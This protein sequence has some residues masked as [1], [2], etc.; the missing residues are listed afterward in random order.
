MKY[1]FLI[2]MSLFSLAGT[3]ST[4]ANK[5]NGQYSTVV[6][7]KSDKSRE[8]TKIKVKVGSKI[9]TAT[10]LGS[11]T[12]KAFLEMLPLTIKMTDLHGNEKYYDLP[13]NLPTSSSNPGTI[14]DGDLMLFGSR[15]VVLFYKGF[16]TPYSYTRIGRIDDTSGLAAV[17]GSGNVTVTFLLDR[18]K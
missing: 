4:C 6:E 8:T 11:K 15:T 7:H 2:L 14:K 9:F 16:S 12:G 17:L 13:N 1:V 18:T 3:A 5:N 10:L